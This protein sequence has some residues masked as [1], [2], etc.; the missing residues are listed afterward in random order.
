MVFLI[1]PITAFTMIL[2]YI[3][4]CAHI[5]SVGVPKS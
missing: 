5:F 4:I 1:I 3:V 2:S